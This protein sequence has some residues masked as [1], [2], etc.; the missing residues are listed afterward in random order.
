MVPNK[1]KDDPSAIREW[2]AARRV[3]SA[4]PKRAPSQGSS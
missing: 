2:E 4:R 1:L 3:R